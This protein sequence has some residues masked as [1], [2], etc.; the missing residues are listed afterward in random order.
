MVTCYSRVALEP[1]ASWMEGYAS[2]GC[3]AVSEGLALIY[4]ESMFC[5]C[6]DFS[7]GK[8]ASRSQAYPR[9]EYGMLVLSMAVILK[10]VLG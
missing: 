8:S 2:G 5:V 3:R 10:P 6:T 4:A 1:D 9:V 7:Y